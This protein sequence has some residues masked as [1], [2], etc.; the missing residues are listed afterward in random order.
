MGY[1]CLPHTSIQ[2]MSRFVQR[3]IISTSITTSSVCQ[4]GPGFHELVG[5]IEKIMGGQ[6]TV[7]ALGCFKVCPAVREVLLA[8][9]KLVL[10]GCCGKALDMESK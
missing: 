3:G 9:V 2:R 8:Q 6:G 5:H 1:C 10:Q 7:E 4:I